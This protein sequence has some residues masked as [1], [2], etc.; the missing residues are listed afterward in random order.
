MN[1]R[2]LKEYDKSAH[3]L[4]LEKIDNLLTAENISFNEIMYARTM[5]KSGKKR[6]FCWDIVS[7]NT[8]EKK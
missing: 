2:T 5:T 4:T 6:Y 8:D 1:Q 3:N 7:E